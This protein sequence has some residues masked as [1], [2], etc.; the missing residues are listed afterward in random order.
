MGKRSVLGGMLL[1]VLL[2]ACGEGDDPEWANWTPRLE[3]VE[4][5]TV[6][7]SQGTV[8]GYARIVLLVGQGM[9]PVDP[10]DPWGGTRIW[11]H[12][13]PN[14]V[15]AMTPF[16]GSDFGLW[17]QISTDLGFP[18]IAQVYDVEVI[19]PNG[20]SSLLE[21]GFTYYPE[22]ELTEVS[23]TSGEAGTTVTLSLVGRRFYG[24]LNVRIGSGTGAGAY[25]VTADSKETATAS[26]DID[27]DMA[28][29]VYQVTIEN[30]A[31]CSATL[32]QAFEVL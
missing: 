13:D 30:E 6:C 25:Q 10:L 18:D 23:P 4:P 2:G 9:A 20:E 24:P 17:A 1:V 3:R 29:G 26:I 19:N 22:V 27:S 15:Y 28:P 16:G 7:P 21:G 32:D 12:P 11:F 14:P 31:G 8:F 5:A